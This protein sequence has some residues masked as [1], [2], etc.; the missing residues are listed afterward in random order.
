[1]RVVM[2]LAG[3]V[4]GLRVSG[5]LS[6]SSPAVRTTVTRR[7]PSGDHSGAP[8]PWGMA[9]SLRAS[10]PV[11]SITYTCAL[12][13]SRSMRKAK[14]VPSGDQRGA[15]SLPTPLVKRLGGAEPSAGTTQMA[16]R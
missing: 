6:S 8:A 13:P 5:L 14:R 2:R 15:L 3:G 7:V 9:L 10:P 4:L 12:L 1:L 16:E 11:T